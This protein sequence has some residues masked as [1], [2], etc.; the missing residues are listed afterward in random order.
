MDTP[1]PAKIVAK[2]SDAERQKLLE[3]MVVRVQDQLSL[4]RH[5]DKRKKINAAEFTM[6]DAYTHLRESLL[7]YMPELALVPAEKSVKKPKAGPP[8]VDRAFAGKRM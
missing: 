6:V 8:K 7:A 1:T 4:E 3:S 2:L 5:Y